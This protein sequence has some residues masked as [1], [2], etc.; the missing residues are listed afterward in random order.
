M[1]VALFVSILIT[2]LL[3]IL[4]SIVYLV[5]VLM[6]ESD[7]D[8]GGGAGLGI[9]TQD[10]STTPVASPNDELIVS[11]GERHL[12]S[13]EAFG[14]CNCPLP[15]REASFVAADTTTTRTDNRPV[16]IGPQD[17]QQ[18][19]NQLGQSEQQ[20]SEFGHL[21]TLLKVAET[22]DPQLASLV[23]AQL[24][25]NELSRPSPED[26]Q[27]A[28]MNSRL[29]KASDRQR[30]EQ[31]KATNG[32]ISTVASLDSTQTLAEATN[33]LKSVDSTGS[34]DTD[35]WRKS[36]EMQKSRISSQLGPQVGKQIF[37]DFDPREVQMGGTALHWCKTRRSLDKL[38]KLGI[39]VDSVNRRQ[40]TP[41]HV[42]AR[43]HKLQVMI[44]LL[45]HEANI[46]MRN[47]LGE[48]AL[49]VASKVRNIFAVQLLLIFDANFEA[50]DNLGHSARH[51]IATIC[52]RNKPQFQQGANQQQLAPS[53]A[54]LILAMLNEIGAKRCPANQQAAMPSPGASSAAA[55]RFGDKPR[56]GGHQQPSNSGSRQRTPCVEGCSSQGVYNGNS[57]NRW[58]N[59]KRESLYKRHMFHDIIETKLIEVRQ[60]KASSSFYLKNNKCDTS[61]QVLNSHLLCIDGGGLRGVIV[62]QIM[63]EM[64]KYLKRP[65]I[66]YFDWLGGTSVGAFLACALS[67]GVPLKELRRICFDV[68][69]EVFSGGRPYNSK[70]L[71]RV[72]KRTYGPT[73]RLSDVKDRKLAVTTVMADR[74]P[75][76]LRLFRN[77][78]SPASVLE[79]YGYASDTFNNM[80]GHSVVSGSSRRGGQPSTTAIETTTQT[81]SSSTSNQTGKT[82][83]QQDQFHTNLTIKSG[84]EKNLV[85]NNR[86]TVK[87]AADARSNEART[88]PADLDLGRSTKSTPSQP[89]KT[90]MT[91]TNDNRKTS[92]LTSES[93]D[94]QMQAKDQE[95]VLDE[96]DPDPIM[97]QAVRASTAA[98]FF[99]KPYGP[100]LDGGIISNNPTLDM[101]NEFES[102]QKVRKFLR[103]QLQAT[104][105]NKNLFNVE[106]NIGFG[107][108]SEQPSKL[109][110]VVSLGTGRGRVIGRQTMVDFGQVASGFATVFSPVELVRS[111]RAARDFFKKL[112]QQS[113][114]TEDYILDRAQAW[115]SSLEVPYF[116]INP[117][118]ATIFSIDDKRDEQLINAL[119]QTKLYM[120]S[121]K[122]QLTELGELLD[123]I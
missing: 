11:E 85:A 14:A 79:A 93:S 107:L 61:N 121:M 50:Q 101:L 24:S 76:Q 31:T 1:F 68:K 22:A 58:P 95:S 105:G 47:E 82:L 21:S 42:A 3:L 100:Y 117:P 84:T 12:Q 6:S 71:E 44:G 74:E 70:F 87:D 29:L 67:I 18:A 40:E 16:Q 63:I 99:F 7:D 48:T 109:K 66:S 103:K 53:A 75:C 113:C 52:E 123:G 9:D 39:P 111:I 17:E 80:S 97:W 43:R 20:S 122:D 112:M 46:E 27:S 69:D 33:T 36:P 108:N 119:W 19:I 86:N 89:D 10:F 98:P 115:C 5:S 23:A 102:Y 59:F 114:H 65:M 28:E 62:C 120:R 81:T 25:G 72:L 91:T 73:T 30:D 83:T 8:Q 96:N 56:P 118:L 88:S 41:L 15:P 37:E 38:V 116:R 57:Y 78:K 60:A 104:N 90:K 77:Y 4:G 45:I 32:Q 64:E 55:R 94:R 2:L 26:V 110:L 35:Y 13:L 92:D 34:S 54:H 49:I 51:Y 106:N